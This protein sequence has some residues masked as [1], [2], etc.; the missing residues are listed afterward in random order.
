MLSVDL[1]RNLI[2]Y[3]GECRKVTET[4]AEVAYALQRAYQHHR[5]ATHEALINAIW[6][7]TGPENEL[8]VMKVHVSKLRAA[9]KG[10]DIEIVNHWGK[11]YELK[12]NGRKMRDLEPEENVYGVILPCPCES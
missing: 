6:G 5:V 9:L 1:D 7:L 8:N 10:W 4:L 3:R 2:C 11:G 12:F